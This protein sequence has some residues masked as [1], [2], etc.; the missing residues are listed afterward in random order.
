M[1]EVLQEFGWTTNVCMYA[2]VCVC[3]LR[4]SSWLL[5]GA[6]EANFDALEVNPYQTKKQRQESEVKQ[7]LEKVSSRLNVVQITMESRT[8]LSLSPTSLLLSL[9]LRFQLNSFL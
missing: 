1:S 3:A 5:P 7:L 2:C 8:S 9:P 6:G 4:F